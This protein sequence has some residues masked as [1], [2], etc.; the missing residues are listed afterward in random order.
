MSENMKNLKRLFGILLIL[1]TM[2][3][4]LSV[5]ASA[6][7]PESDFQ[8]SMEGPSVRID[9]YIGRNKPEVVIPDTI[10]GKPVRFI[11][12]YAFEG[13][14]NIFSVKLPKELRCIRNDAFAGC[15][16]LK[17][18]IFPENMLRITFDGNVF[19]RVGSG[20]FPAKLII[21]DYSLTSF[22]AEGKNVQWLGGRFDVIRMEHHTCQDEFPLNDGRCDICGK[23]MK[24][25]GFASTRLGNAVKAAA[26]VGKAVVSAAAKA[27]PV[28]EKAVVEN[29]AKALTTTTVVIR[30]IL[31]LF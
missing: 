14:R 8:Y 3:C 9:K 6:A 22:P 15:N 21:P 18:V 2:L 26:T 17:V 16:S 10:E 25:A 4:L 12:A 19:D 13:D 24:P 11:G 28:V 23:G 31:K 20:I 29:T 1:V 30:N 7:N 27:A 5:T